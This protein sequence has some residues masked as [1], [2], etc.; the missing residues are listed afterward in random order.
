M[1]FSMSEEFHD[2][3]RTIRESKYDPLDYTNNVRLWQLPLMSHCFVIKKPRGLWFTA[4]FEWHWHA[5]PYNE[6]IA[7]R[8]YFSAQQCSNRRVAKQSRHQAIHKKE[9]WQ[10]WLVSA[11]ICNLLIFNSYFT[12]SLTVIQSIKTGTQSDTDLRN[13]RF[14]TSG[15]F[16][17]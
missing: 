8:C 16:L 2:R 11:S 7:I 13:I 17:R 4:V 5:E 10:K 12:T 14:F 6:K 1:V 15:C 9:W 3:W